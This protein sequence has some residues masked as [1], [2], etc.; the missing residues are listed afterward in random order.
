[1]T[2]QQSAGRGGIIGV[3]A[4]WPLVRTPANPNHPGKPG[5]RHKTWAQYRAALGVVGFAANG[6]GRSSWL[7]GGHCTTASC[8]CAHLRPICR[9]RCAYRRR[10]MGL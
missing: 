3:A 2:S 9:K 10:P 6:A 7:A 4:I 8:R 5:N 1:V